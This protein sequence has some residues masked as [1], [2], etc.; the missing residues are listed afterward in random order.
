MT[1]EDFL[2]DPQPSRAVRGLVRRLLREAE[3]LYHRSEAGV[4]MLPVAARPGI[5]AARFVYAGIGGEV[6]RAGFDSIGRRAHTSKG[7]KIGWLMLSGIRA[8]ATTVMPGSAVRYAPP[9]S[10]V[11]F[12]VD[13]AARSAGGVPDWGIGRSGALV[14]ILAELEQRD[15][16]RHVL[17]QRRA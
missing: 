10:E 6:S 12:L 2:A 14:S 11:Q 17:E 8:A 9:M 4:A 15:R 1:P 7:Q 3:R 5:F 13:A 16:S